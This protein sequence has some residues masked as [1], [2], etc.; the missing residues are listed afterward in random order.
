[1]EVQEKL[2]EI[3]DKLVDIGHGDTAWEY[4]INIIEDKFNFNVMDMLDEKKR[5]D[6]LSYI[7][8]QINMAREDLKAIDDMA[9]QDGINNVREDEDLG[10]DVSDDEIKKEYENE[11]ERYAESAQYVFEQDFSDNWE[12]LIAAVGDFRDGNDLDIKLNRVDDDVLEV[13]SEIEEVYK[14]ETRDAFKEVFDE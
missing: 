4:A 9:L 7:R 11:V 2:D 8:K 12:D 10:D 14:L 6:V 5:G 1:M 3:H 13:I